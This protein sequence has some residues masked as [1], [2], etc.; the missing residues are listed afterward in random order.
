VPVEEPGP[1]ETEAWGIGK[2][3]RRFAFKEGT[4]LAEKFQGQPPEIQAESGHGTGQ[5]QI[6]MVFI[7][8]PD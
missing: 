2:V 1:G 3:R 6:Q 8:L 4:L 5:M 7:L